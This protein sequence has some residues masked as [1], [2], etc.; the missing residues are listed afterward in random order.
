MRK[1]RNYFKMILDRLLTNQSLENLANYLEILCSG[2]MA[3]PTIL[4]F[5]ELSYI[6]P[7]A[8]KTPLN[9]CY[10]KLNS[11]FSFCFIK[12]VCGGGGVCAPGGKVRPEGGDGP[13]KG[14]L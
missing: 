2:T 10:R 7:V 3:V 8:I 12:A 14:G 9:I 13:G 4:T 11:F 5:G 1:V 6:A